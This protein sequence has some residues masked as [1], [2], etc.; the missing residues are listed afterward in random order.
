[1]EDDLISTERRLGI[2][3]RSRKGD[4]GV[5]DNRGTIYCCNGEW[6]KY[7]EWVAERE[8][9]DMELLEDHQAQLREYFR[10]KYSEEN[11]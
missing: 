8:R 6:E 4:S 5:F 3:I 7:R 9:R 11:P 1:M 2:I 10:K